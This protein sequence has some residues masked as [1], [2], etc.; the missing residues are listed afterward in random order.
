MAHRADATWP[1]RERNA[2][3]YWLPGYP[4][5][6]RIR[7][8]ALHI[9]GSMQ[10]ADDSLDAR[11]VQLDIRNFLHPFCARHRTMHLIASRM[12]ARKQHTGECVYRLLQFVKNLCSRCLDRPLDDRPAMLLHDADELN[13][14]VGPSKPAS[15]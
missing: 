14:H 6:G 5:G 12:Q 8:H 11:L 9:P 4:P 7:W 1:R 2:L 3:R 10:G 15:R 13:I